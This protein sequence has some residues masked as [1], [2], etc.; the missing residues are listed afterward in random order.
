[1][2][3][4]PTN[5]KTASKKEEAITLTFISALCISAR[6]LSGADNRTPGKRLIRSEEHTSELQSLMRISYAV[7]CLK[8]KRTHESDTNQES[9]NTIQELQLQIRLLLPI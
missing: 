6:C 8:K 9:A 5:A 2:T 1:M 7:S 4:A 3:G